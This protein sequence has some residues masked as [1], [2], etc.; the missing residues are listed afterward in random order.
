MTKKEKESS[1]VAAD[2][3]GSEASVSGGD[4][5]PPGA[6]DILDVI[7]NPFEAPLIKEYLEGADC[8]DGLLE[9]CELQESGFGEF[10]FLSI[11]DGNGGSAVSYRSNSDAIIDQVRKLLEFHDRFPVWVHVA[12][13]K[14]KSGQEYYSLIG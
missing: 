11:S 6:V 14:N 4:F 13:K 9:G 7:K 3:I 1:S 8:R 10:A 12:R 5:R 2:A